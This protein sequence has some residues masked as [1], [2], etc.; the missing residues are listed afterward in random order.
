MKHLLEGHKT[1]C[2]LRV[3]SD[4]ARGRLLSIATGGSTKTNVVLNTTPTASQSLK[5]QVEV[6]HH[7]PIA[8]KR[9]RLLP[10]SSQSSKTVS[11]DASTLPW[12][13]DSLRGKLDAIYEQIAQLG[14]R[15]TT[16]WAGLEEEL[17]SQKQSLRAAEASREDTTTRLAALEEELGQL[18]TSLASAE[19]GHALASQWANGIL[20]LSNNILSSAAQVRPPS[21]S[22]STFQRHRDA[23]DLIITSVQRETAHDVEEATRRV[24][25]AEEGICK[26]RWQVNGAEAA[27]LG[28]TRSVASANMACDNHR[29][30]E[31]LRKAT[32]AL[33]GPMAGTRQE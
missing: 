19:Q 1:L 4:G 6:D 18:K 22:S 10:L 3:D 2:D 25:Q 8:A 32:L 31:H 12:Q 5:R 33:I 15:P 28:R 7:S 21:T 16:D 26:V 27:V 29:R 17:Q 23:H 24:R 11:P 13:S 14:D 30:Y 9:V 20:E